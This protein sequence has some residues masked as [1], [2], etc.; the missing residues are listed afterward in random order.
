LFQAAIVVFL[1]GSVLAGI[2]DSMGQLRR[3]QRA[4]VHGV[5]ADRWPGSPWQ[6]RATTC[7]SPSPPV[8]SP[9]STCTPARR[10]GRRHRART[11]VAEGRSR[12]RFPCRATTLT[13]PSSGGSTTRRAARSA[14]RPNPAE[15]GR[16]WYQMSPKYSRAAGPR[17]RRSRSPAPAP[18]R[19]LEAGGRTTAP[20]DLVRWPKRKPPPADQRPTLT[21]WPR[22]PV[23]AR[24]ASFVLLAIASDRLAR[25]RPRGPGGGGGGGHVR[26]PSRSR[27]RPKSLRRPPR[28]PATGSR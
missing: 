25:H 28:R 22:P 4:G 17:E 23:E 5:P 24:R 16:G 6:Q 21:G 14:T 11:A 15:S 20:H 12:H 13:T 7:W 27:R 10:P 26:T 19:R 8:S 2:S 9:P 1:I 18:P 3:R